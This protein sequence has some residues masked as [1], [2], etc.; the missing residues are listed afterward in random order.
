MKFLVVRFSSLGDCIL[1]CPLLEHLKSIGAEEVV[2]LTKRAYADVFA[3]ATG[4]DRV[5]ALDSSAGP[6]ALWRLAESF[7]GGD[8]SVIDAHASWRS[9]LVGWR[10]GRVD[11]RIAK[12][13]RERLRLIVFKHA[14]ALPSM[15]E[16]YARLCEP[17][18]LPLPVLAPGGLRIP[19]ASQQAA[20]DAM[21][22]A[23]FVAVAP[24]SRWPAKRW[25][26]FTHL[27]EMLPAD[28][29]IL[30]VGDDA[31]RAH[32][33]PIADA[34]GDRCLDLAGRFRIMDVAAHIARARVFVGNDSGLMHLAE[35]VGVP[36]VALFG[37]TVDSF[38]YYPSL[39]L[40]RTVERQ[41]ACRPCSRN[42]SI[43]CPRGTG[44]CLTTISA[45][46][47]AQTVTTLFDS[48]AER[49]VVLD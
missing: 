26:G 39:P 19:P 9:R 30:L 29:R 3:C 36:V 8:Y 33:A 41:L 48:Q 17:L 22:E 27:C 31:D 35:A 25:N 4:A 16:R 42:G 7:R 20:R 40:S 14:V 47:V 38:G 12:H 6:G 45:D 23:P 11:T 21:G 24:G 49:R 5:V 28:H 10:A 13:T 37:P 32:T 43:P 1:L 46:V 34:L 15:L 44:E 2:V 18:G